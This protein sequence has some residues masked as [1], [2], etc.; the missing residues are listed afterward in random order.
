MHT[1]P[2][3]EVVRGP[4]EIVRNAL[5]ILVCVIDGVLQYRLQHELDGLVVPPEKERRGWEHHINLTQ[6]LNYQ[7][8]IFLYSVWVITFPYSIHL[9]Y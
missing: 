4:G 9:Q 7:S 2:V 8:V 1:W 6:E 3:S 5:S